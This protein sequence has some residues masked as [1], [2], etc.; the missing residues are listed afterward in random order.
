MPGLDIY[1]AADPCYAY[2]VIN[3]KKSFIYRLYCRFHFYAKC[4]QSVFG[5]GSRTISLMI[6][7]IQ[8]DIFKKIYATPEKLLPLLP[9]GIS[10]DRK[11]P[12]N[13]RQIRIKCRNE[14]CMDNEFLLLMVGTAFKTKGVDRS[15]TVL[16]SLPK[17]IQ[18][19][20]KLLVVGEGSPKTY[21]K[22]AK[23]YSIENN[24]IFLGGREDIPKLLLG[25]DL[26]LHPARRENAGNV[27]LE[28]I[29]AG[30]PV[31]TS[32]EC[33]HYKHV[34]NSDSGLVIPTPFSQTKFN[35]QISMML[36]DDKLKQWSN[37]GLSYAASKDLYSMT[38]K[39]ADIIEQA[40]PPK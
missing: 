14:F 34:L 4:E 16:A 28:A 36:H 13:W 26:L 24:V 2:R 12:N 25:A 29:V 8:R 37:N 11:R 20:T 35:K 21:I 5:L 33:G 22:L 10:Q 23:Q 17:I 15:I 32:G 3:Q 6:S 40:M 39:A 9:P 18:I 31:I 19:K 27:I 1:Y 38:E 30:L 7:D